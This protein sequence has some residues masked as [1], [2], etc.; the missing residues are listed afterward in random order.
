MDYSPEYV[1]AAIRCYQK[2]LAQL[3]RS[4]NKLQAASKELIGPEITRRKW[5]P[6]EDDM[7]SDAN[8]THLEAAM[9]IGRTYHSVRLRREAL[10]IRTGLWHA[11]GPKTNAMAPR[12]SNVVEDGGMGVSA[13]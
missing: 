1:A 7:V 10:K 3:A 11:I 13:A 5:T 12:T 9:L 6:A 4:R 8:L 2:H